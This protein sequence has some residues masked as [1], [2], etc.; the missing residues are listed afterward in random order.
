MPKAATSKSAV[1][2]PPGVEPATVLR[3][4]QIAR[5]ELLRITWS[6]HP[7]WDVGLVVKAAGELEQYVAGGKAPG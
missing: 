5:L 3:P 1:F 4:E 7:Q 6:T 2:V